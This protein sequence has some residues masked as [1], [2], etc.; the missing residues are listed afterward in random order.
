MLTDGRFWIGVFVGAGGFYA[1]QRY[2]AKKAG[3]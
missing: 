1:Y 2:Q 3:G